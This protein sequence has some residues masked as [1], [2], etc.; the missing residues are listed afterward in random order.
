MKPPPGAGSSAAVLI[1]RSQ[2]PVLK[3]VLPGASQTAGRKSRTMCLQDMRMHKHCRQLRS[4]WWGQSRDKDRLPSLCH[5]PLTETQQLLV[6]H[7]LSCTRAA[8]ICSK[9]FKN[10]IPN[11]GKCCS[12]ADFSKCFE[13]CFREGRKKA[14]LR[15]K[16]PWELTIVTILGI[17]IASVEKVGLYLGEIATTHTEKADFS[18]FSCTCLDWSAHPTSAH[19]VCSCMHRSSNARCSTISMRIVLKIRPAGVNSLL[20]GSFYYN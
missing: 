4:R 5:C 20:S 17:L 14:V 10:N 6:P 15:A 7:V 13:I 9:R 16:F 19:R 3:G 2:W 18:W 12:L 11:Q 1:A 8:G